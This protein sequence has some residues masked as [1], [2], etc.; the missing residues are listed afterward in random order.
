MAF[1]DTLKRAFLPVAMAASLIASPAY[2]VEMG[3]DGCL[4][5]AELMAKLKAEGQGSVVFGDQITNA[6]ANS[7]AR[8]TF[9]VFTALKSG[10]VGKGYSFDGDK[11]SGTPSTKFCM[12]GEFDKARGLDVA[13]AAIPAGISANSNLVK[14]INHSMKI[15]GF[16]PM[17]IGEKNGAITVVVGNPDKKG[18]LNGMILVGNDDPK[19]KAADLGGLIGLDYSPNYDRSFALVENKLLA[20]LNTPT[21]KP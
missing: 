4:P 18:Q 8:T 15:D 5:P 7:P 13:V 19:R 14:S 21:P 2:A 20:G 1:K 12:S 3:K 10:Q 6:T 9:T 17:F 11:P 16:N